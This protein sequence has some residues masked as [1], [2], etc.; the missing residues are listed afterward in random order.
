M[1]IGNL[2]AAV[3]SGVFPNTTYTQFE[4]MRI[5][6]LLGATY[7]DGTFERSL[8]QDGVNLPQSIRSWKL[9]VKKTATNLETMF[10]FFDGQLGG[11]YPFYWYDP[12]DTDGGPIGS[13]YDPTG[14]NEVGRHTVRF[15]TQAWNQT[16]GVLRGVF[17]FELL[18]VA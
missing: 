7:H 4:E 10:T 8:I 5:Y 3:P 9:A 18:E 15:Q 17:T 14:S 2:A 1:A 11:F 6:P 13:N 12:F 16:I